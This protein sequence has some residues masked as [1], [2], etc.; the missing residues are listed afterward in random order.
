MATLF[1]QT[2]ST[3][4][5]GGGMVGWI[6]VGA[7][8]LLEVIAMWR[9]FE[10]AKQPG[11]AAIIPI[12]NLYIQLKI[13][14][15]PGWWLLLYLI[16]LVNLVVQVVVALDIAKAFG[17]S[18]VFGIFGLWLFSFVGYLMLGYGDAKYKAIKR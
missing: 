4:S 15:R 16:P 1:A 11:W 8:V 18:T 10:K 17:K 7:L 9:V 12:Y 6:I 13:A 14:N 3:D 2:T 5:S